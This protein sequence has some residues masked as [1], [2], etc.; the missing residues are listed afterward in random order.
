ML[1]QRGYLSEKIDVPIRD[2]RRFFISFVKKLKT[3]ISS[4]KKADDAVRK[5]AQASYE[6]EMEVGKLTNGEYVYG[7]HRREIEELERSAK[8]LL[9]WNGASRFK[10]DSESV[11]NMLDSINRGLEFIDKLIMAIKRGKGS[12]AHRK[13]SKA[14][15]ELGAVL[16]VIVSFIRETIKKNAN[17]IEFIR[18]KKLDY[19]KLETLYHATSNLKSIKKL[20]FSK[21]RPESSGASLGGSSTSIMRSGERTQNAISF[22]YDMHAAKEILRVYKEML[23]ISKGQLKYNTIL[24]WAKDDGVKDRVMGLFYDV[25]GGGTPW[26]GKKTKKVDEKLEAMRIYLS[27]LTAQERRFSPFFVN[28]PRTLL[29]AFSRLSKDD[30]GI[31]V[32]KVDMSDLGSLAHIANER[33]FRVP[34]NMVKSIE[35]IIH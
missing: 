15:S 4:A 1:R 14:V 20:G 33:E 12:S 8:T 28:R 32:A 3:F 5:I 29:S 30:I 19:E 16:W 13:A 34:V 27:Y 17:S 23:M 10:H 9:Y 26:P 35:K 11:T 2:R 24:R 6:D 25:H 21:E 22:T 31:V 7:S 18:Y